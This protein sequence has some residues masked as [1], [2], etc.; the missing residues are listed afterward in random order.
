MFFV[1]QYNDTFKY[2]FEKYELIVTR[3]DRHSGWGQDLIGYKNNWCYMRADYNYNFPAIDY[4]KTIMPIKYL[5][6]SKNISATQLR[7]YKNNKIGL[8]NYLLQLV[9]HVLQ[10]NNIPYY[11]DCGTLLGCI[12]ENGLMEKDTDVDITIH[13]SHWDELQAIDF[14]KY[15]LTKTRTLNGYP[16]KPDGNMISCKN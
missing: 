7:D 2:S 9:V 15:E 4:V 1:H 11:L 3:T 14:H 6:Y 10:E 16:N 13:L 8:M 12:R 5:P